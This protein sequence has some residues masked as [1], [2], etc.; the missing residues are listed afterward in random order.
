MKISKLIALAALAALTF[1]A[2]EK[3]ET[4]PVEP[5]I[6]IKGALVLNNGNWGANDAS[7]ALYNPETKDVT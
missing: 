5:V 7:M 1:T 6:G 4:D 2:C 3:I